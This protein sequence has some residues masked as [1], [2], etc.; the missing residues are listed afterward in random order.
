[1]PNAARRPGNLSVVEGLDSDA[2]MSE[3][4]ATAGVQYAQTR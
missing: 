4:P 3:Q 1:M 2:E